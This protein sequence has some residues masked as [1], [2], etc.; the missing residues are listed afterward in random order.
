MVHKVSNQPPMHEFMPGAHMS[1][2]SKA[3]KKAKS[4]K[5]KRKSSHNPG[6]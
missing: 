2:K 4:K 6:Y 1:H 3:K 5:M